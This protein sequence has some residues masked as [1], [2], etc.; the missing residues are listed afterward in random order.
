[1]LAIGEET[2][3]FC[4][5]HAWAEAVDGEGA[6][7]T[8]AHEAR[9]CKLLTPAE[10][11]PFAAPGAEAPLASRDARPH[12]A[13]SGAIRRSQGDALKGAREPYVRT[14]WFD[15]A[16]PAA[17][18]VN[19]SIPDAVPSTLT[20]AT[21]LRSACSRLLFLALVEL[22]RLLNAGLGDAGN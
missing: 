15:T 3:R 4:V 16:D 8:L 9:A 17:P 13:C 22:R 20:N 14:L 6:G 1:M 18:D 12:A 2:Q 7:A 21:S 11:G 19:A 5:V 10:G